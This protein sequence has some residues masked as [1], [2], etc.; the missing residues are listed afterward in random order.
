MFPTVLDELRGADIRRWDARVQRAFPI[1]ERIRVKFFVDLI[2]VTNHTIFEPPNT[3]PTNTN[4][5]RVTTV[6]GR[7]RLYQF[8]LRIEF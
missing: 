8:T 3:N 2:N 7:P 5:G 6:N 1:G 4:F